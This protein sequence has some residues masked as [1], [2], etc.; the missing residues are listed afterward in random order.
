[1]F[2]ESDHEWRLLQAVG[3]KIVLIGPQGTW[4]IMEC[5][6]PIEAEHKVRELHAWAKGERS[7]AEFKS[8]CQAGD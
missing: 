7:R 4:T 2:E 8:L 6:A 3:N 1:V 5:A